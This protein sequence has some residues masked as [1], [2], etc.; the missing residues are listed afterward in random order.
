[1]SNQDKYKVGDRVRI[2]NEC[3]GYKGMLGT[4]SGFDDRSAAEVTLDN[5]TN[6]LWMYEDSLE[7]A[8]PTNNIDRNVHKDTML[9]WIN[10]SEIERYDDS[11]NTWWTDAEPKFETDVEYRVKRKVKVFKYKFA[12][13]QGCSCPIVVSHGNYSQT[14]ERPMFIHW[15]G[16]EYTVEYPED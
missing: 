4:V 1:M 8:T 15:I 10:G 12:K 11:C 6:T 13:Y 7:L 2:L 14:E 16:N 3:Y 5:G 9:A